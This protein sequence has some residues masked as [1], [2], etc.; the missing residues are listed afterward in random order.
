MIADVALVYVF[1]SL[2]R[3]DQR[4]ERL[5]GS[6]TVGGIGEHPIIATDDEGTDNPFDRVFCRAKTILTDCESQVHGPYSDAYAPRHMRLISY[7]Y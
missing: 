4:V 6:P 3:L 1:I 2:R 5:A 7:L